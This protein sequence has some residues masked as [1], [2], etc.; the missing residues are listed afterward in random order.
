[1][2]ASSVVK[3]QNDGQITIAG[4]GGTPTIVL[5]TDSGDFSFTGLKRLL[6]TT[7][8]YQ[9]R[10]TRHSLRHGELQQPTISFTGQFLSFSGNEKGESSG[11][12][13]EAA[14]RDGTVFGAAT[15]TTST[16]GDVWTVDVTLT[17]EGTDFGDS[18][19]HTVT[20]HDVELSIDGSE[21]DPTTYSMS[22]TVYGEVSGDIDAALG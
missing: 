16:I 19:D 15:S 2:P 4:S 22:G 12:A 18:G 6:K 3:N 8:L 11:S 21:G 14:L 17:I 20:F 5:Q 13:F 9:T 10:S 7:S 1:M